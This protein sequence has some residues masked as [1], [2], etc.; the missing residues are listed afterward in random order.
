MLAIDHLDGDRPLQPLIPGAVDGSEA[1]ASDPILDPESAQD[2]LT[3][4]G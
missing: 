3:D 4:H 1:A 2:H